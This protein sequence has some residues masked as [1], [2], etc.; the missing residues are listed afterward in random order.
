MSQPTNKD[1]VR[2]TLQSFI[3]KT[4]RDFEMDDRQREAIQRLCQLKDEKFE[5]LCE[6]I[7][8]EIHRRSGMKYNKNSKIQDKFM[9]L[10]DHKFKNLVID[11]LTVFYLKNP[12]Y[13]MEEMPE[14]LE[15][16]KIL[17]D[18][19]KVDSEKAMFLAKLEKLNFYNKLKEF[20]EYTRKQGTDEKIV[21][22][23]M[24][25]VDGKI[26][27]DASNFC[28]ILSFPNIFLEKLNETK[29]FKESDFQKFED[30][31]N[32]ILSTLSNDS[33][34]FREKSKTIKQELREIMSLVIEKST[35]PALKIE[36][37]D[38]EIME[39]IGLLDLLRTNIESSGRL[40]LNQ[41]GATFSDIID[42]IIEKARFKVDKEF[43]SEIK[44]QKI[45][46]ESLGDLPSKIESFQLIIDVVCDV[47][48]FFQKIEMK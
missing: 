10:S 8:N 4:R 34:S 48:K 11:T 39:I 23:V 43:I 45:S 25:A 32:K 27:N 13:K 17:I 37:F 20:L 36:C 35:I 16:M 12:E 47:R 38:D 18:Q 9:K 31:R 33:I 46:L 29:I 40:D 30:H 1:V 21:S 24:N 41:I 7:A 3:G 42:R 19:L 26:S 44:I 14:F 5:E 28:E 22:H 2:Y 15:N 6:D